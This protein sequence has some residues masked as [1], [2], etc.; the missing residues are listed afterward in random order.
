MYPVKYLKPETLADA[1]AALAAQPEAKVVAGGQSLI[2]AMK[3]RFANP[4]DLVDL[5]A[6]SELSGIRCAPGMVSIGAMTRHAEVAASAELVTVLPAL[7]VL[8]GGIGDR[9]VRNMGTIG[10]S[11]ANNDPAA[12]YPAGLLALDAVVHT[13]RRSIAA[14]DFFLGMYE[15]ALEEGELI[16]SVDL[17]VPRRAA[18]I[19]FKSPASRFAL[20]GVFVAEFAADAGTQVRVAVTGAAGGVFRVAAMERA[21]AEDFTAAAIADIAVP[22]SDLSSDMHTSAAYRSHLITVLAKRAVEQ[23]RSGIEKPSVQQ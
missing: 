7:T 11:V 4:S 9:M 5:G 16:V 22:E 3:L 17:R 6:V 21:L 18:Y 12:D 10:G 20:V 1:V 14:D 8:A 15:T 23:S 2:A 13:D 19:K